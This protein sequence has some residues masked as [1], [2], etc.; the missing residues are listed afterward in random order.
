MSGSLSPDDWYGYSDDL[1]TASED[2][3]IVSA[4]LWMIVFL[5]HV[6]ILAWDHLLFHGPGQ[7]GT[8]RLRVTLRSLQMSLQY[9][10]YSTYACL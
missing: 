8:P 9:N 10:R 4:D 6:Q 7:L 2:L 1:C 5:Q 3:R